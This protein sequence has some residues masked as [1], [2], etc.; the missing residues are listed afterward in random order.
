MIA[1]LS[2]P[3]LCL[4][5]RV[6]RFAVRVIAMLCQLYECHRWLCVQC[7]RHTLS[8]VLKVVQSTK[9]ENQNTGWYQ[10]DSGASQRGFPICGSEEKQTHRE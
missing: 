3:P 4:G 9:R 8:V 1:D 7:G 10:Q 2:M 5:V 6:S